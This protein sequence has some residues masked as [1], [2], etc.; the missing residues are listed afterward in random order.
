MMN[1]NDLFKSIK[2]T[3]TV[4]K[5]VDFDD[6]DLHFELGSVTAMEEMKIFEAC[7][8]REGGAFLSELKRSTLA[9]AIK[10]IND[11]EFG[12]IVEYPGDDGK[13]I[14][15][16]KY[17]FMVK[18]IDVL[19]SALRDKLFDAFNNLQE[20]VENIIDKKSKF[21]RFKIQNIPDTTTPAGEAGIPK[22]FRKIKEPEEPVEPMDETE[23]INQQVKKEAEMVEAGMSSTLSEA[24]IRLAERKS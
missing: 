11:I 14:K 20:E 1:L 16:S 13:V 6:F 2:K 10:R 17:L 8:G 22:G 18:Q 24:E 21:E 15:E 12:D 23:R 4:K 7:A 5:M 19:P 3:F 9:H